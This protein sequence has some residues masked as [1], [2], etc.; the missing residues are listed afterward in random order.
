ML[1]AYI[2]HETEKGKYYFFPNYISI[3]KD[4]KIILKTILVVVKRNGS[5]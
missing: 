3:E 1:K 4:V 2:E 5:Y